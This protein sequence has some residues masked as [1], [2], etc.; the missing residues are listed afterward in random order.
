[1]F[2]ARHH[3]QHG[4]LCYVLLIKQQVDR[5]MWPAV[6]TLSIM[7]SACQTKPMMAGGS[8][9]GTSS[10]RFHHF[11][12]G[13]RSNAAKTCHFSRNLA[14]LLLGIN[15]GRACSRKNTRKFRGH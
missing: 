12:F 15:A 7:Q 14:E 3:P 10:I 9:A 6:G 4:G 2:K 13:K 1:L 11:L 8:N 5:F